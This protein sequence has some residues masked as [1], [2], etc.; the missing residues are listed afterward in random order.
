MALW[1][2]FLHKWSLARGLSLSDWFSLSEAWWALA[3]FYLAVR[4]MSFE[5]LASSSQPVSNGTGDQVRALAVARR[6]HRLTGW[7]ARL[8]P[9]SMTCLVQSL[10]LRWMLA[11]RRIVSQLRIGA[12]RDSGGFRIH[13]WLEMGRE[14]VG[15]SEDVCGLFRVLR[16]RTFPP[17]TS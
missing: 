2:S 7:A 4:W 1:K 13:A 8:H 10:A 11:R 5:R 15:A 14:K 6:L 17:S 16:G 12:A 3:F 9:L